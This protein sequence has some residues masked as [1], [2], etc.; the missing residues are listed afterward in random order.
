LDLLSLLFIMLQHL[1][2]RVV[3]IM[4]LVVGVLLHIDNPAIISP[5]THSS[6]I[7]HAACCI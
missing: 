7:A 1:L 6:S 5:P 2:V 4:L 3:V